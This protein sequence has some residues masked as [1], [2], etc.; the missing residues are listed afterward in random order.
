MGEWKK[1]GCVLCAQN[2]GIEV[3]IEEGRMV[4]VKADK[5]NPRS[6]GYICRK[7]LNLI[8]HQYPK[9]RLGEPLKRVGDRFEPVFWDQA[10]TEI[11]GKIRKLEGFRLSLKPEGG[12]FIPRWIAQANTFYPYPP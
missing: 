6:E 8:Y 10:I 3:L 12:Y 1:T 5:D 2:C 11:A 4:K 9:D 7:G